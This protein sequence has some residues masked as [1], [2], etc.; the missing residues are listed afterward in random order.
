MRQIV[1]TAKRQASVIEVPVLKDPLKPQEVRGRT[2]ISLTSPGTELN[3]NYLGSN[4]PAY[5]GYACVF[6]VEETGSEVTD[7]PVGAL[8][9]ASGNHKEWQIS[10]RQGLVPVPAG[11]SAERAVFARLMGVSMST[12]N[13]TTARPPSRVLIT[14]LGPV[15]NLAAQIFATCGYSVTAVDPVEAR[16]KAALDA[17]LTDVRASVEEGPVDIRNKVALHVECSGHEKAV[18]DGL[19]C[20]AKRGEVVLVGVP[21]QRRTE[22]YAFDILHAVFH[23]YVVLRTGWEWEVPIHP[24]E[25]RG[26]SSIMENYV[27]AMEWIAS[28]KIEV[29][30]LATSY[31]PSE[32]QK[33]YS[34]LLDQSLPTLA[35]LFD[36]RL[37]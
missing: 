7:L 19:K 4:F 22:I 9:F 37:K 32:A 3:G 18:L 10:N 23:R 6:S 20:V 16:R 26:N 24:A 27:A 2:V 1:F 28:G 8:V 17:G 30:K 33:V 36:W 14:G 35:A 11:L 13:T 25:F 21:W 15:G 34:G 31:A 12:L 29:D 5:P